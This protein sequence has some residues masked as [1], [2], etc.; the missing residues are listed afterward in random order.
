MVGY[1][2][3]DVMQT[4]VDGEGV[5]KIGLGE[6]GLAFEKKGMGFLV[7]AFYAGDA[8]VF[9][10]LPESA[11]EKVAVFGEGLIEVGCGHGLRVKI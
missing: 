10:R 11:L 6:G 7:F 3:F 9:F 2:G 1:G 5:V 4:L 8:A